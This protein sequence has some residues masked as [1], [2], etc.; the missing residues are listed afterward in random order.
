MKQGLLKQDE[1]P[2][3]E[4]A[5][6]NLMDD[7]SAEGGQGQ[8][9]QKQS[10]DDPRKAALSHVYSERFDQM[11]KM[12]ETNGPENFSKSMATAINGALSAA[13]PMP[14]EQAAEIGME[15]FN[16]I[17]HDVVMGGVLQN[18]SQEEL[19]KALPATIKMYAEGHN[20]VTDQDMQ[21]FTEA[22]QQKAKGG[23]QQPPQQPMGGQPNGM[24]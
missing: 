7:E 21:A 6:A 15:L 14:H 3:D 24:A 8:P 5:T 12:F 17:L 1:L 23:E 9:P 2:S 16:L 18:I 22:I 13:G 20:D 4:K 10:S 11:L 19:S